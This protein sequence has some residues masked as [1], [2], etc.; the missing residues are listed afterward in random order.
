[1]TGQF[2]SGYF[3]FT[4]C[5]AIPGTFMTALCLCNN[6]SRHIKIMSMVLNFVTKICSNFVQ[7]E[8]NVLGFEFRTEIC[9]IFL[10]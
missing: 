4:V 1:M 6:I 3:L 2:L 10:A 7:V 8:N 9:N 5:F